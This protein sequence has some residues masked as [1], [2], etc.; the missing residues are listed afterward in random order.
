MAVPLTLLAC[1]V[2]LW[3]TS[4]GAGRRRLTGLLRPSPVGIPPL[5]T[6]GPIGRGVG[7]VAVS[8]GAVVIGLLVGPAAGVAGAVAAG[9]A[10]SCVDTV[11]RQRAERRSQDAVLE[12]VG[13]LT[14]EL[15]AGLPPPAALR[16]A[17]AIAD[18]SLAATLL[19]AASTAALGG[20]AAA[21]LVAGQSTVDTGLS[22]IAAG[23]RMSARCGASLSDVLERVESDLRDE[24]AHL[25]RVE[26][27]LAGP[28]A[29]ALL[30]AGLPVLGLVLGA[31]MGAR[32]GHVLL[33]T[34]PGQLALILGTV[35]DALGMWW[36]TRI[37]GG[38]RDAA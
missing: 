6:G 4:A 9:C 28:R 29:T 37:I 35:L 30:L 38:A 1:S 15:R 12:T 26:A 27:E 32:P 23:W 5:W 18:G 31:S 7:V 24:R 13:A 25:R 2:L 17:A 8:A 10:L 3:P 21:S 22:R 19:G 20:D 16:A 33:H 11:L 34:L 14:G 36:T